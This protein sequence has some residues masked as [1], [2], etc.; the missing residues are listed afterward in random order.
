MLFYVSF[1]SVLS[2][3][4]GTDLFLSGWEELIIRLLAVKP[5]DRPLIVVSKQRFRIGDTLKMTCI[6]KETFPSANMTWFVSGKMVRSYSD[7]QCEANLNR[8]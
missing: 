1:C 8:G 4:Y 6:L 2:I 5:E 3:M 7:T